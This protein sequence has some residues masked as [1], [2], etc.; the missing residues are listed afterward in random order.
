MKNLLTR[1]DVSQSHEFHE[2]GNIQGMLVEPVLRSPFEQALCS[3]VGGPLYLDIDLGRI[4]MVIDKINN[5]G[6]WNKQEI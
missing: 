3:L 6:N 4:Q 5:G 2:I 1:L